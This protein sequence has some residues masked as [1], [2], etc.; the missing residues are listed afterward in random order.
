[1]TIRLPQKLENP[2]KWRSLGF[3]PS[4]WH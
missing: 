1:M 2:S 4:W 3:I